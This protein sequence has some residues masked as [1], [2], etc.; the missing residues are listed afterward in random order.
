MEDKGMNISRA[1]LD[2]I[3]KLPV[4]S[5]DTAAAA[6]GKITSRLIPFVIF[7]FVLAFL[8]RINIGFAQLQMKHDL[9]LSD[10]AYG[11]ASSAFFIGYLL[12]E[13]PSN[14]LLQRIGARKTICRIL[15]LWGL[16]SSA[17]MFV[18]TPFQLQCL[19]FL[20]GA[21]EA[22][23]TPGILLYLTYWYPPGRQA[24]VV[25]AFMTGAVIA[26]L[27]AG[28]TSSAIMVS[29]DGV[30][31]IRGWRWLF[32]LEGLPSILTGIFA[33]YYITDRPAQARWLSE[34]EKRAVENDHAATAVAA[35]DSGQHWYAIFKNPQVLLFA[36]CMF[37]TQC[38]AYVI[39]FWMPQF[40]KGFKGVSI[41]Q[42]GLYTTLPYIAAMAAM[43]L[44]GKHSDAKVERRWHFAL[45][46]FV[47]S[48]GYLMIILSSRSL[49]L[50]VMAFAI[51]TS[52]LMA[53]VGVF[54][55]DV[56][57]SLSPAVRAA[58][59]AFIS[60]ISSLGGLFS[61]AL[62][63]FAR[64][65]TGSADVGLYIIIFIMTLGGLTI[66][67]LKGKTGNSRQR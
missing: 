3:G 41:G 56:A 12:F 66:L 26:G 54:W 50:T 24:R 30:F 28:P 6:Y 16:T 58:G 9:S 45:P 20:L 55:A 67:T 2:L 5:H 27:V 57:T 53:S 10:T 38:G 65:R 48:L 61:P 39:F 35:G 47:A 42:V 18:R 62:I 37:A 34:D 8:D 23:F 49:P 46:M 36:F 52:A 22:G 33:F 13:I 19:R 29:L 60:S 63:G 14:L 11:I 7:C 1:E 40:L 21:F 32:L 25:G 4:A 17:T 59:I 44:W 31:G 15:V 51:S 64:D 43:I